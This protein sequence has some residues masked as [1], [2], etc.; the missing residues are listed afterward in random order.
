MA[1]GKR[2]A[3]LFEVIQK[4]KQR[5]EAK[6]NG[7]RLLTPSWWFK[8]KQAATPAAPN[9][10]LSGIS[11]SP[12]NGAGSR[13]GNG[14]TSSSKQP[15]TTIPT[16]VVPSTKPRS[17]FSRRPADPPAKPQATA[18]EIE[19]VAEMVEPAGVEFEPVPEPQQLHE[20]EGLVVEPVAAAESHPA[21]ESHDSHDSHE[22]SAD[23]T[24]DH[25]MARRV[26]VDQ[27][28]VPARSSRQLAVVVDEVGAPPVPSRSRLNS[29]AA[30]RNRLGMNRGAE[31]GVRFRLTYTS[32][33]ISA[34]AVVVLVGIAFIV[35]KTLSRGPSSASAASIEELKRGQSFPDVLRV[36]QPTPKTGAADEG[37]G[38]APSRPIPQTV[39]E[40]KPTAKPQGGD[41]S[42]PKTGT[43]ATTNQ[44]GPRIVNMQYVLMQSYPD[45][46]D[47]KDA[48]ELLQKNGIG[49]TVERGLQGWNSSQWFCVVG[50][51]GFERTRSN[52]EFD[53]YVKAIR[54]LNAQMG[55][56]SKF[57]KFSPTVIGWRENKT[58]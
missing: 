28:S 20:V 37:S 40:L 57:K 11:Q 1:K 41:A 4:A 45:S 13:S 14:A 23:P 42:A 50:T 48:A 55:P 46:E 54:D 29:M 36:Q 49:C 15:V 6:K 38:R 52:P 43:A 35:G 34:V 58:Q 3:A 39:P 47:A 26:G 5:E 32:A 25:P 56:N 24:L 18:H 30:L 27:P 10:P 9:T 53:A 2:A 7:G 51:R 44:P 22:S 17:F 12:S 19:P 16:A 8:G 31:D 21:S 33:A